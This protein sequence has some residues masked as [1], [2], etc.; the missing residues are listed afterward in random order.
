MNIVILLTFHL[1]LLL[2][3]N[4]KNWIGFLSWNPSNLYQSFT[5]LLTLGFKTTCGVTDIVRRA[6][7]IIRRIFFAYNL[8]TPSA[9]NSLGGYVSAQKVR[10]VFWKFFDSG[11]ILAIPPSV[12]LI[13][14]KCQVKCLRSWKRHNMK[15]NGI[16][17]KW[18]GIESRFEIT[19][20]VRIFCLVGRKF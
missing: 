10:G 4:F 9:E 6:K 16:L 20:V 11:G 5:Y 7:R 15:M 18:N 1:M 3:K 14:T 8:R 17:I 12:S 2:G 19:A 13:N